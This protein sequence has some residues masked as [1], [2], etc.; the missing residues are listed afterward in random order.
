MSLMMYHLEKNLQI[1]VLKIN[2][3]ELRKSQT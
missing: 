3:R 1:R 2:I